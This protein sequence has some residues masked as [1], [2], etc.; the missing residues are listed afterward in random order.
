MD[1]VIRTNSTFWHR[2]TSGYPSWW[3]YLAGWQ[4]AAVRLAATY[5]VT[6]VSVVVL[7]GLVSSD[8][9]VLSWDV[10]LGANILLSV[11][12]LGPIW[13]VRR[14]RDYGASVP[15]PVLSRTGVR[16]RLDGWVRWE[17]QGRKVWDLQWVR[18]LAVSLNAVLGIARRAE[19][20]GRWVRVPRNFRDPDGD[21]VEVLLPQGFTPDKGVQDRLV[22]TAA[23]RLGMVDPTVSWQ[24]AGSTPRVLLSTPAAPPELVTFAQ[25]CDILMNAEEYRPLLGL[26]G[27]DTPYYAEMVADSPHIAVS[28]GPGAGKSTLAKLIG[29]QALR[30]GWGLVI[31][32]WKMTKAFEWARDLPGVLILSDIEAIHDFGDR[33]SQEIDIRK[34]AGLA[35]RAKVL[36]IRDEWNVTADLLMAYWQDLRSTSE[37]EDRRTMPV[38]SPALRGFAALD[39]AGREFGVHDLML[40]QRL[41]ARAFNGNADIRECF[42]I[43]CLARYT[44]QTKKML[45]GNMK[46]FPKKSN[47]PGRWTIVAGEDVVVVQVPFIANDE[48]REFA[49]GGE[50]NPKTPLSSSHFPGMMQHDTPAPELG[51]TLH[52]DVTTHEVAS[53]TETIV[54]LAPIDARKLSDMV[55]GLAHLGITAAVLRNATQRPEEGFPSPIGGSPNR[56]YTYDFHAVMVWAQRRHAAHKAERGTR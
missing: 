19:Y 34:H 56:G 14:V 1:N 10:V 51:E 37:P 36:V 49:M 12:V 6:L 17:V 26:V 39:F 46:P 31:I 13:G 25:V 45:V 53:G 41:S 50:P 32:D 24:L 47:V 44:E 38:K 20:A 23:A 11:T 28:A 5:L 33:I 27:Q 2:A 18:P 55:D 7:A 22:R 54:G 42:A 4:R 8:P 30:W 16:V 9:G 52:L 35:G 40:G 21:P 43:R 29:M 3:L 48:A 15:V